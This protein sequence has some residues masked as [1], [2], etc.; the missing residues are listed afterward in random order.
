MS[1]GYFDAIGNVIGT[2]LAVDLSKK[3][4]K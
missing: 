4:Q 3:G 1:L 2:L